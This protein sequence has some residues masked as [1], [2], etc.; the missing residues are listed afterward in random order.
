MNCYNHYYN[1]FKVIDR[2][3]I[4]TKDKT[5]LKLFFGREIE[6]VIGNEEKDRYEKHELATTWISRLKNCGFQL[7]NTIL[8]SPV[9]SEA[10]VDIA[11]HP[12]GFLGFTNETETVLAV[13]FAQ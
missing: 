2:L 4:S 1:I 5:G 6:D 7:N 11:Y 13:M 8:K 3:E 10:G 12:E 9:A